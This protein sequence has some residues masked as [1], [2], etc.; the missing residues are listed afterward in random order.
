VAWGL[1][2]SV[3]IERTGTPAVTVVTQAFEAAAAARARALGLPEHP[4]VV[5]EHP[6]ASQPPAGVEKMARDA[7]NRVAA[8][9]VRPSVHR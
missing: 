2:D 1:H 6:L 9:L 7:A 3:E 5:V 8:A 4:R